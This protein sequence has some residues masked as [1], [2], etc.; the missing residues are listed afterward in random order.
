M[1][2]KVWLVPSI[3]VESWMRV[4]NLGI[5]SALGYSFA[6][7]LYGWLVACGQGPASAGNE[8]WCGNHKPCSDP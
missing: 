2:P 6:S 7:C 3:I 8:E 1:S 5:S 4:T